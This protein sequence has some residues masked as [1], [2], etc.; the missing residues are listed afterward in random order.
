MLA[1]DKGLNMSRCTVNSLNRPHS[2]IREIE[3]IFTF[4]S[5]IEKNVEKNRKV[6]AENLAAHKNSKANAIFFHFLFLLLLYT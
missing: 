6:S 2:K 4:F 5:K 1:Y 3:T